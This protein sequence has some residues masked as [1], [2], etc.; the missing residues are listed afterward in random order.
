MKNSKKILVIL[1]PTASGKSLL[2]EK[3]AD[4]LNGVIINADSM[5]IYNNFPILS[6]MPQQGKT[7]KARYKLYGILDILKKDQSSATRWAEL[8]AQEIKE[9]WANQKLPILVGGTGFYIKVLMEGISNIPE[10]PVDVRVDISCKLENL[11]TRVKLYEYLQTHDPQSAA[12]ISMTDTQRLTRALEVLFYTQKPLSFWQKTSKNPF[13]EG[14]FRIVT[15][16]PEREILYARINKRTESMFKTNATYE[17]GNFIKNGGS[18][19]RGT[20]GFEEIKLYLEHKLSSSEAIDAIQQK[21]RNY[22]KRQMTWL[23]HQIK[24]DLVINRLV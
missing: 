4:R 20:I 1:G 23:R 3:A 14:E 9:A 2:A 10:I 7:N 21:T 6:A 15:L 8:A 12:T 18:D 19:G 13:I 16:L 5:Q 24:S 22:A 11:S 17:V